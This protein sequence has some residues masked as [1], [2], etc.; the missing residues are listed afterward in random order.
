[1]TNVSDGP[2]GAE[3]A[4]GQPEGALLQVEHL[5]VHFPV[6]R[7]TLVG[8]ATDVVHAVDGVSFEVRRGQT[9]GLVG[10]SGCGKTTTGKAVLALVKA[11]SGRVLLDGQDLTTLSGDTLRHQRRR[12]QIVFQDPYSSLNPRMTVGRLVG[13]ALAIHHIGSPQDRPRR[14]AELM[15]LVG[16]SPSLVMRYPHEFSGG[17]KQRIAIARALASGPELVVL[18]E[19]VSS[20]DVSIQAQILHLL[21]DLQQRLHLTYL[22]IAHDLAVVGEMAQ[23]IAV[24]YLGQIVETGPRE[25][26]YRRLLHPYSRALF[27]AVPY[28]DPRIEVGRRRIVL[29]GDLPSPIQ[30]PSGCRFHT[31][32]PIAIPIC[33]EVPPPLSE[34]E[35]GYRAA[36]HRVEYVASLPPGLLAPA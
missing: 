8:V 17:Q 24:M 28:P 7:R 18:D 30:P 4:T 15:D 35:P 32:C 23:V 1:M 31:R 27:S 22:L 10:E 26:V 25:A 34:I 13:E 6:R 9:L 3:A 2:S 11:T 21:M 16:L 33:R 5:A 14:V 36:C 19:P 12:F 29:R 20:L